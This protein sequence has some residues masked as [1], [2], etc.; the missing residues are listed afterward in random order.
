[1]G[2]RDADENGWIQSDDSS[3]GHAARRVQP[4]SSDRAGVSSGGYASSGLP[5]PGTAR[6]ITLCPHTMSSSDWS[7]SA[8][9]RRDPVHEA[10]WH[11]CQLVSCYRDVAP[12]RK[13]GTS[14][15]TEGGDLGLRQE[16]ACRERTAAP[17]FSSAKFGKCAV[18]ARSFPAG[19]MARIASRLATRARSE[20]EYL[21]VTLP[22][23]TYGQ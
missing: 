2:F 3:G 9:G 14:G 6:M 4:I 1:M 8:S 23:S 22:P 13:G 19:G 7:E 5:M 15:G 17:M 20:L 11:T 18:L 10:S 21:I 16:T 12:D